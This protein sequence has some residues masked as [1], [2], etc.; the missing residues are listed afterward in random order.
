MPLA[1]AWAIDRLKRNLGDF[2]AELA[3]TRLVLRRARLQRQKFI[4]AKTQPRNVGRRVDRD[5]PGLDD[6][7]RLKAQL[8]TLAARI[9]AV[10]K[11]QHLAR[12]GDQHA[13]AE[14]GIAGEVH[15][16]EHHRGRFQAAGEVVIVIPALVGLAGLGLGRAAVLAAIALGAVGLDVLA[17]VGALVTEPGLGDRSR[18]TR[19]PVSSTRFPTASRRTTTSSSATAWP[20]TPAPGAP[21][22]ASPF[23]A[24]PAA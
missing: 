10:E 19:K 16:V 21:P 17:V 11:E 15:I 5:P 12:E 4:Q 24:R 9:V 6:L 14:G 3:P 7:A 13:V 1:P 23:P 20:T 18:A 22:P 8:A 2:R